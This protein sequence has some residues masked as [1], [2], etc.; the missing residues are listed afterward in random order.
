MNLKIDIINLRTK[1]GYLIAYHV[2][3]CPICGY[4]TPKKIIPKVYL[5]LKCNTNYKINESKSN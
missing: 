5:C 4:E 3:T 2:L 1:E